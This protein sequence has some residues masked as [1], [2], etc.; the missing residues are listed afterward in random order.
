MDRVNEAIA[1]KCCFISIVYLVFLVKDQ[2]SFFLQ[3]EVVT[4]YI[5]DTECHRQEFLTFVSV[6]LVNIG[7]Q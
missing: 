7:P 1:L 2:W 6:D 5:P 3:A 4:F